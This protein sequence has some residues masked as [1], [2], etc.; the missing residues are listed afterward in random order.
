MSPL[1]PQAAVSPGPA[2]ARLSIMNSLEIEVE[3]NE[4]NI[5]HIHPGQ[6]A[7]ATLDAYPEWKIPAHVIAITLL[8]KTTADPGS[9]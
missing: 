9:A 1:L 4:A 8:I 5:N 7:R 6:P 3:V 2:W